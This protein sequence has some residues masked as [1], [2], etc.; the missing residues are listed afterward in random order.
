MRIW[1]NSISG[2]VTVRGN[3]NGSDSGIVDEQGPGSGGVNK[4]G[5]SRDRRTCAG[6][7]P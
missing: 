4:W 2:A 3:V 5:K 7:T 1:I 6:N